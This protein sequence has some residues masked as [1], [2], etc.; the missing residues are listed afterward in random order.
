V[1]AGSWWESRGLRC[2]HGGAPARDNTGAL[3][4]VATAAVT[5]ASAAHP[6]ATSTTVAGV[7]AWE[8]CPGYHHKHS[9]GA[10]EL[11]PQSMLLLL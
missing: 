7:G 1:S 8:L 2:G 5:A 9:S 10:G 6:P 11:C 4:T 3:T